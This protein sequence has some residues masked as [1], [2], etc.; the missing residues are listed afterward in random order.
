MDTV[1]LTVEELVQLIGLK[2]AKKTYPDMF[3][4]QEA[5]HIIEEGQ[6][7]DLL[8]VA[9]GD[10]APAA[11]YDGKCLKLSSEYHWSIIKRNTVGKKWGVFLIPIKREFSKKNPLNK[12]RTA[13]NFGRLKKVAAKKRRGRPRK[14]EE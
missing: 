4:D 2:K 11:K 14:T 13:A 9:T 10:D 8:S 12:L 3:K 5:M 6:I 1:K 7:S